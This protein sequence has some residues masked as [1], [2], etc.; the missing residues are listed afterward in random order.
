MDGDLGV[1]GEGAEGGGVHSVVVARKAGEEDKN[2]ARE[3]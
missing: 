2:R 3:V 1:G